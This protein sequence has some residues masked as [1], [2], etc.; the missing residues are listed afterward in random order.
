MAKQCNPPRILWNSENRCMLTFWSVNSKK[1]RLSRSL[2]TPPERTMQCMSACADA[3][4]KKQF[5]KVVTIYYYERWLRRNGRYINEIIVCNIDTWH[6]RMSVCVCVQICDWKQINWPMVYMHEGL[7][8]HEQG[9][10]DLK[11][12]DLKGEVKGGDEGHRAEGPPVAVALLTGMVTRLAKGS[13][14][15][16]DLQTQCLD[17][18]FW[19]LVCILFE[20]FQI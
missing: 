6:T 11:G 3:K 7:V 1:M 5:Q 2:R 19:T 17:L 13:R 8:A 14:C 18:Q 20:L 12:G 9:S 16:A 4:I 10:H 15:K